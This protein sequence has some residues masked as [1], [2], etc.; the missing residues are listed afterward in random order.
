MESPGP[1]PYTTD[2]IQNITSPEE[3]ER[4]RQEL[5]SYI[6]RMKK[7]RQEQAA[8][9]GHSDYASGAPTSPYQSA[10]A[11]AYTGKYSHRGG[12]MARAYR[13]SY[14]GSR[15]RSAYQPYSRQ[16]QFR[17]KSVTFHK[18][19]PVADTA[20]DEA[21][22]TPP[23]DGT[24]AGQ[25]LRQNTG[26]PALCRVFTTTV[27]PAA[28]NCEAFGLSGYCEKGIDCSELHAQ[29]C[30]HFS[31]TNTCPYGDICRL[32]HVHR[33]TR[34]RKPLPKSSE[35]RNTTDRNTKS[36]SDDADDAAEAE[37]ETWGSGAPKHV[38]HFSQQV[39]FVP[40]D[41]DD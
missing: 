11:A 8:G 39:D 7:W 2:Q 14:S 26:P 19:D 30:P 41:T 1:P 21:S 18:Q 33:A 10:R 35:E 34:M 20:E 31:N 16:H 25:G 37:A 5:T 29:E 40:L 23:M 17:N 12:P 9:H 27:N 4:A 13:G 22:G 24:S 36:T 28:L 32:G 15:G 3:R 38:H 6:A